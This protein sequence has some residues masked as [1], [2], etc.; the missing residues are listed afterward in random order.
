MDPISKA[1]EKARADHESV[2]GWVQPA[3]RTGGA[4][5]TPQIDA[6]R[7]D[8]DA[9]HLKR[10]LLLTG[11]GTED[12]VIADKYRLL[13]TRVLLAMRANGWKSLGITSAGP[14]A[15]KTVTALNLAISMAR[16]GNY[17]VVLVDAD[18]RKP[19]I[20][21]YLGLDHPRG[22]IAY[23]DGSVS[24]EDSLVAV[25]NFPKLTVLP[26]HPDERERA[27]T[28]LLKSERMTELMQG[29]PANRRSTLLIVDLP[30]VLI[31]DDVLA[32]A[33]NLDALLLVIDDGV[34]TIDEMEEAAE[35]LDEFNIIGTVLNKSSQKTKSF[36]SYY[37]TAARTPAAAENP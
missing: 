33:A 12:P 24:L 10:N 1:L 18:L 27:S 23:L 8:V 3:S 25:S 31:G 20:A 28:D 14:N 2:R 17:E 11:A 36:E 29:F 16:E 34:T 15:G 19:S 5:R 21:P 32:V 35:L 30:P 7:T 6:R 26:G 4:S 37:T 22:L 9:K 13:R